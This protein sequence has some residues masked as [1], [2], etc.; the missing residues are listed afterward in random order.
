MSDFRHIRPAPVSPAGKRIVFTA[1]VL[2]CCAVWSSTSSVVAQSA[3]AFSRIGFGARGI[4]MGNALAADVIEPAS[5]Y[6]NPAHAPMARRQNLSATVAS[7]SFDRS[8]H[9]L[10]LVAPLKKN[11]GVAAGLIHAAVS[12]IDGRDYSGFHT[13]DL[14]IDEYAAFLAF[15]IH[16]SESLSA[17]IG[18]KFYRSDLYDGMNPAVSMG[19]DLGMT[20][21]LAEGVFAGVVIDDL[22]ARYQWNTE[23]VNG[24]AGKKTTDWFPTRLRL[25][26]M[27]TRLLDKLT[28]AMEYEARFTTSEFV[29]RS[30]SVLG[31]EPVERTDR[32]NLVF[33]E[34]RLRFGAEYSFVP[35]FV[36]RAGVEQ[37]GS[38]IFSEMRPSAGFMV[39]QSVGTLLARFE[40][41]FSVETPVNGIMHLFSLRLFL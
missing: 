2:L 15:G 32:E 33:G 3:G 13:R 23:A 9:F 14:S 10:Q 36:V 31:E 30:V 40:Y 35:Q 37:L 8:L 29:S 27:T 22:L 26:L 19:I 4:A 16:P 25:G 12:N 20:A 21:R 28:L 18:V 41:A 6:Y 1:S 7:L 39:E 34:S 11:A 38:D 24:S 17:G 5:P